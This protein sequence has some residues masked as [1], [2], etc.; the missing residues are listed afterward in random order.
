M[1]A[2][3]IL[4]H[5][6]L[7]FCLVQNHYTR[8]IHG[9]QQTGVGSTAK[10]EGKDELSQAECGMDD[11]LRRQSYFISDNVCQRNNFIIYAQLSTSPLAFDVHSQQK[12]ER[13]RVLALMAKNKCR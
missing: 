6:P 5:L 2:L 13:M 1:T 9:T 4:L 3:W 7:A 10:N 12:M 8:I 11:V